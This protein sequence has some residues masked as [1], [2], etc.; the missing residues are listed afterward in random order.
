MA[1]VARQAGVA[2]ATVSRAL[3]QPHLVTEATRARVFQAI[4]ELGYVPN[5]VAGALASNRSGIIA[6]TVPTLANSIFAETVESTAALLRAEGYQLLL[7]DTGYADAEEESLVFTLLGRQPDG[8]IVTGSR[9]TASARALLRG[10]GIPVVEIWEVPDE[11][12]DSAVGFNNRL[13]AAD[14]ARHLVAR[15]YRSL[16]MVA[17]PIGHGGRNDQ[18]IAGVGSVVEVPLVEARLPNALDAGADALARVLRDHPQADAVVCADDFLALGALF[19]CQRHGIAVPERLAIT[20]FGDFDVA[21]H[22]VP[23][24]TTVR[25]PGPEIGR[26]AAGLIL[27]RLRGVAKGSSSVP[28]EYE[29]VQRESA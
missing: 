23:T 16:V 7:G 14:L 26:R 29:L 18:R 2:P 4:E 10:A 5:L 24:L 17:Q 1:D 20:G 3:R 22:C 8:F 25:I 11:P 21:R 19:A 27:D 28:L 6:M 13:A 12:I 15:G 9:H